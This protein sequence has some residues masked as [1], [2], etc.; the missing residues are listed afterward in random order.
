MGIRL[1][2]RTCEVAGFDLG[3]VVTGAGYPDEATKRLYEKD[4]AAGQALLSDV[5]P[6]VPPHKKRRTAH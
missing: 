5:V 3:W 2:T 6:V 4:D 1:L